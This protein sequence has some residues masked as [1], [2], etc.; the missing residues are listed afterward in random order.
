MGD[1]FGSRGRKPY[2]GG[3]RVPGKGGFPFLGGLF[4]VPTVSVVRR[5]VPVSACPTQEF[6]GDV[7]RFL[8]PRGPQTG[9]SVVVRVLPIFFRLSVTLVV[10]FPTH[11]DLVSS[12]PKPLATRSSVVITERPL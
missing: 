9:V 10:D 8:S 4:P 1:I 2:I 11:H 5:T 6:S 7:W 12:D 3:T